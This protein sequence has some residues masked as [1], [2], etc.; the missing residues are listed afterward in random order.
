L[1]DRPGAV[2][3]VAAYAADDDSVACLGNSETF[4]L[5][6]EVGRL[7]VDQRSGGSRKGGEDVLESYVVATSDVGTLK[8]RHDGMED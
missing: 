3:H 8:V 6:D 2:H 7:G 5:H 4:G 1:T